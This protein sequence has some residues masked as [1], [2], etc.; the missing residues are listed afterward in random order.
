MSRVI[1][2]GMRSL[3]FMP[4]TFLAGIH[5]FA[6]FVPYLL[7]VAVLAMFL[8]QA[9]RARPKAVPIP[10]RDFSSRL[11]LEATPA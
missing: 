9:R 2:I 5:G 7:L 10:V 1:I 8:A 4:M 11:E 3:W 6:Y